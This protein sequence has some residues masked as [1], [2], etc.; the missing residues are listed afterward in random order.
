MKNVLVKDAVSSLLL[1][2][3]ITVSSNDQKQKS[4]MNVEIEVA[5]DQISPGDDQTLTVTVLDIVSDEP[6]QHADIHGIVTYPSGETK[7]FDEDG[8]ISFKLKINSD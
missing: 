7:E 3:N 8:S 4:T 5:E 1:D 6:I 2:N